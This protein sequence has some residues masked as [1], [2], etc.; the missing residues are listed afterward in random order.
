MHGL[1]CINIMEHWL[2]QGLLKFY[3]LKKRKGLLLSNILFKYIQ[4][5]SG[6]FRQIL[7]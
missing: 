1:V 3:F 5:F 6:I 7:C 2:L 4:V